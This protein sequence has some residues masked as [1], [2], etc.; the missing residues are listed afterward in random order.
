MKAVKLISWILVLIGGINWGLIGIFN[1]DL[2][3][4]ILGSV[5]VVERIVYI[6]VGLG[7]LVII[8]TDCKK[9]SSAS[10]MSS[11]M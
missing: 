6:L 5:P 10:N 1:W 4:A 8:F 2:V 9:S 11:S 7:A 3:N